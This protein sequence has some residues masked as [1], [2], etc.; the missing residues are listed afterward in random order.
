MPVYND[1]NFLEESINSF[2]NQTLDDIE[3]VCVDD[4]STD[5]SLH[6]LNKFRQKYEFI[7]V[8]SQKNQGSGKARNYGMS[9]AKGEFIAFLDSDDLFID[10]TALEK[11]YNL[12]ILNDSKMVSANLKGIT[13]DG[14][15][16][17]NNDGVKRFS[18]EKIISGSEYGIPY[19]FYKNIFK[20][21]F[22]FKNNIW[23]PDFKRGQD[24]VFLSEIITKI[25]K[26]PTI[27]IDFYGFRYALQGGLSKINTIGKKWDYISHFNE[28]F[29]ILKRAGFY[30][31]LQMYKEKLFLYI[32][33]KNNRYDYVIYSIVHEIFKDDFDLLKEC[34]DYF[35]IDQ[36]CLK[37]KESNINDIENKNKTLRTVIKK[38]ENIINKY[39]LTSLK[40]LD[41][42]RY[43]LRNQKRLIEKFNLSSE[44][45]DFD[46]NKPS[47][48]N[49]SELY[50]NEIE[51][52]KKLFEL[53]IE[54]SNKSEKLVQELFHHK[55]ND[56][57]KETKE[58]YKYLPKEF[59]ISKL[60]NIKI[61]YILYGF[62]TLSET[63]ILNE[64]SWLKNHGL[65]VVVF[66]YGNPL[67]PIK[68]NFDLDIIR[69]DN[70]KEGSLLDNLEKLL[71]EHKI[72]LLHTHFVFP[73]ATKYTFPIAEK[74]K[75]PFTVFAHAFDIFIKENDEINNIAEISQ[76]KY[77]KCIFTLSEYHKNYLMD[78][79]VPKEKIVITRQASEYEIS[80]LNQNNKKISK[81]IS[82]SRFVEKKGLDVLIDAANL[83]KNE[84]FEFSIY[85]FGPLEKDLQKK[86]D[87]LKLSN[88][89]IK[90]SLNTPREVENAFKNADLL[91]A[92]CKI[93]KN[94]DRDGVP[95]VLFESM[96]YGVPV[97]TTSVSAI[98][99]FI[100]DGKNGFIVNPDDPISLSKKIMQIY[101][102]DKNYLYNIR[103]NAQSDVQK[104]SSIDL[105]MSTILK[106]WNDI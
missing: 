76:S 97:L 98:P 12:A 17:N 83:L 89:S 50:K 40:L 38:Q 60:R 70:N 85:G 57:S 11:M 7:R 87:D 72:D 86:I 39:K 35:E 62:P 99:E 52:Y 93:A 53:A 92:P 73:T 59:I 34:D 67:K 64:L 51:L 20:R 78:R 29:N 65:N 16:V 37:Q 69:F 19:A 32:S 10:K 66:S 42:N 4:G 30:D 56:L 31:T 24:P 88:I 79:N 13:A 81:I 9:K 71:K 27:P 8:F 43:L 26:I 45:N 91:V 63:F 75:I 33:H 41:E 23:F 36:L 84:N 80:P 96:G 21:S 58:I 5:N 100:K 82:I 49:Y 14:K 2:L 55:I 15:F 61:G 105:T 18:K 68:P 47:F 74:L 103:K 44:I 1:E 46:S 22:L 90:G 54:N 25:D 101:N 28:T 48:N 77:C 104:I 94:G 102:L 95:T 106:I 3:L 6:I